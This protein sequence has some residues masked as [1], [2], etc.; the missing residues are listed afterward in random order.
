M[1]YVKAELQMIIENVLKG[2]MLK[3]VAGNVIVNDETGETLATRLATIA[4]GASGYVSRDDME[5]YV[6]TK[7]SELIDGAPET[8]NTLLELAN[9]I[10]SNAEVIETLNSA[11]GNKVDKVTGKGL[12]SNDFT[13]TLLN[14]L[15]GIAENA[16]KV[17][18]SG[19]NGHLV[20]N[21]EDVTV[22]KHPA[23]S[24][25][26]HLPAGGSVGQVAKAKGDG[27]AEWGV[28][29]RSGAS[30]PDN[31]LPGEVFIKIL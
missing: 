3:T 27:T 8:A 20:I 4:G 13:T 15:N 28:A 21:G 12:S 14:K 11:I 23:G 7:L 6:A 17:Q 26:T 31:L 5:S 9:L 18:K 19:T 22:Y 1:S 29:I 2:V 24:G 16:T 25:Y 30:A 10:S